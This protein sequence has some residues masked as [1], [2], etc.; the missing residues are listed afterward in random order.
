MACVETDKHGRQ[1]VQ[2]GEHTSDHLN[3]FGRWPAAKE[4]CSHTVGK[5]VCGRDHEHDGECRPPDW[6]APSVSLSFDPEYLLWAGALIGTLVA[7]VQLAAERADQ[8]QKSSRFNWL[9]VD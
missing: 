6:I 8:K 3:A 1:C 4:L 2:S 9:E 7:I 5:H